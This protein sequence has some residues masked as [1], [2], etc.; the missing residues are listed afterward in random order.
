[1]TM[2]GKGDPDDLRLWTDA[3]KS[4]LCV[5]RDLCGEKNSSRQGAKS[6]KGQMK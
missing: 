1:M 3:G 4:I 2:P 5:L 6:A